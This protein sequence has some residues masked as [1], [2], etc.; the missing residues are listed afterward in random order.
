MA[1]QAQPTKAAP[2]S[3][4]D[5]RDAITRGDFNMD[6]LMSSLA[7]EKQYVR[8]GGDYRELINDGVSVVNG[9]FAKCFKLGD[10]INSEGAVQPKRT[11]KKKAA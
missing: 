1:N 8:S 6:Q 11:R 5:V 9:Q 2:M 3:L 7:A 10:K 4:A